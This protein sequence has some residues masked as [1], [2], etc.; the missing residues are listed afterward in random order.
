[1][2]TDFRVGPDI[3]VVLKKGDISNAYYIEHVLGEGN[4]FLNNI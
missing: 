4:S 3:F 1:M 2:R